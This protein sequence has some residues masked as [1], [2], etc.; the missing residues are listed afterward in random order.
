MSGSSMAGTDAGLSPAAKEVVLPLQIPAAVTGDGV[1]HLLVHRQ[2]LGPVIAHAVEGAG[3]DQAVQH[4]LVQV[5]VVHPAAKLGEGC[6]ASALF[7]LCQHGV[8][9]AP[10]HALESRESEPDVLPGHG[11]GGSGFVDV[12][13][14]KVD[15]VLPALG[16]ILG[17]LV[18][19]VQHGGQQSGH[20][21]P[22]M[23]VL[24][25][26]RLIGHDGVAHG[27]G[28]VEGVVREVVDLVVDG[29][30]HVLGHTVGK[31]AADVPGRVTL[32]EC[33]PLPLDI[34]DLFLGH[35]PA[36]HVGLPQRVARQLAEDLDDLLL[37]DD[38]AV[39]DG[40]D[41]L[42]QRVLVHRPASGSCLQ[43]MNRGMESM[44]PGRYRAMMAVMSSM[45][46]GLRPTHT[47][48]MPAD[49]IWNTPEVRPSASILNTSGSLSGMSDRLKPG[50]ICLH[51]LHRVVQNGQV[52]QAQKVHFQQAQLLQ[53][54]HGVL[55]DH[56]IV[57]GG[58][59]NVFVDG[60]FR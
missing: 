28:L 43:A 59:R 18:L 8:H 29:L 14:Q 4:P 44:G 3:A 40:Q 60:L 36:H 24:E 7:T 23:V 9:K 27:V 49:S 55:G 20:V 12:R 2:Q 6:K 25:P 31:A 16:D 56:Q 45:F 13:R 5:T 22:G 41:R 30:G 51:H 10:A 38:A 32:D 1:H 21:L 53:R 11:E 15:A 54:R 50:W 46:W 35:G 47:P 26:R 33:L 19:R 58:Q 52:P 57:V 42:Q 39:G 34:L 17:H 37:I 48:V